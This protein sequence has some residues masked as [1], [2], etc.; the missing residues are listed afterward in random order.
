MS[1]SVVLGVEITSREY[2]SSFL[3]SP[4]QLTGWVGVLFKLIRG[5]GGCRAG[6]QPPSPEPGFPSP[7]GTGCIDRRLCGGSG[8]AV[9]HGAS[10]GRRVGRDITGT[11]SSKS[12]DSL[13]GLQAPSWPSLALGQPIRFL[14]LDSA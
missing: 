11:S 14:V 8:R 10:D 1:F 7:A 5:V 6:G 4:A 3:L 2:R 12:G 13:E 9:R